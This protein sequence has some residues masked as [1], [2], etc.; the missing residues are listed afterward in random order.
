MRRRSG[1]RLR[2]RGSGIE[3]KSG[4]KDDGPVPERCERHNVLPC[5]LR[6]ALLNA[7]EIA[8]DGV[9]TRFYGSARRTHFENVSPDRHFAVA[10]ARDVAAVD[11][12][13]YA[14]ARKQAAVA[15]RELRQV[16]RYA[17]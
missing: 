8:H 16:W 12:P 6:T 17:P 10:V 13:A 3:H 15:A 9:D 11:D 7:G 14:L 4:R 2:R 1:R 5:L